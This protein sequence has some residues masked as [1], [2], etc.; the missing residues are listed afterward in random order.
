[1]HENEEDV[2]PPQDIGA[3][4]VRAPS[5]DQAWFEH[6]ESIF[7]ICLPTTSKLDFGAR[8]SD[9]TSDPEETGGQSH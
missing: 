7:A 2:Y 5:M 6:L 9:T 4:D 8:L 1:L 3:T